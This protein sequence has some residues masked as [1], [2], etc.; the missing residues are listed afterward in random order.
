M[1]K[2]LDHDIQKQGTVTSGYGSERK[3]RKERLFGM[4]F[5]SR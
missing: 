2:G 5:K 3:R 4:T 1:D